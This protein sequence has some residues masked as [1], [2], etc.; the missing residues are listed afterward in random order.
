MNI[1]ALLAIVVIIAMVFLVVAVPT[2]S[3]KDEPR[4]LYLA[5]VPDDSDEVQVESLPG[6]PLVTLTL[7]GQDWVLTKAPKNDGLVQGA[8]DNGIIVSEVGGLQPGGGEL[9]LIEYYPW[10]A[11]NV[12]LPDLSAYGEVIWHRDSYILIQAS[13]ES[14]EQL[15]LMGLRLFPLDEPISA[16]SRPVKI[17]PPPT[18]PDPVIAKKVRQLRAKDIQAWDRRLS[19][20]VEV[21]IGD[22][23]M[24]LRSRYAHSANG[25][26]A[27]QYV[28][29]QLQAMGYEPAYFSYKTP[30]RKVWRDIVVDIPGEVDP[31][32]LV[33]L[34]GH[35]D[36]IS[37]PIKQAPQAAP[38]ADDNGTG[39]SSLLAMAKLLKDMRFKYT[40]RLVWFTGEEMGYWG[41]RPYVK[42][43]AKE[44]ADV[45]AA[46]NLDMIGYDGDRD[47]VMELHTGTRKANVLL[48]DHLEAANQLYDIGAVIERKE[49]SAARFSDHR[50]FWEHGY[51]SVLLIE[52]FFKNSKEEDTH[53]RDRNPAYH[54]QSDQVNLVDYKYVARTAKMAMAAAMYLAEP[55]NGAP[56]P[57][58][59][60]TTPAEAT[61][62]PIPPTP[63]VTPTPTDPP[64]ET[65]E[66]RVINGG[67][68]EN[69][70]WRGFHS[71][72][73]P[74]EANSGER[75]A[76]L[77][78]LPPSI[79]SSAD[80]DLD[81]N[82]YRRV[83]TR[84]S[85]HSSLYQTLTLPKN[86]SSIT[87][88]F[89]YWPGTDDTGRDSQR[90]YLLKPYRYTRI[91]K[92]MF[93]LENDRQ[94]KQASFDLS[95][96]AGRKVVLYFSVYNN[97]TAAKGRTWMYVDDVSIRICRP[98]T[99]AP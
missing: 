51:P 33:L 89:S 92:L 26:L 49:K 32:R 47:G 29:E 96:Y 72:Y 5:Q 56:R 81:V 97:S 80:D 88:T 57:T 19:G 48:G 82:T 98:A 68:E 1:K 41:S 23:T 45:V 86:A 10:D 2:M 85:R 76:R 79:K 15:S 38:G 25:R 75:A 64:S 91:K 39:S 71:V 12:S 99:P 59:T 24:K 3:Q 7:D 17:G 78:L 34:V 40:I 63:E 53:P 60:P 18:E 70:G 37:Y 55:V 27:E 77:G 46:I 58:A 73:T 50:S 62:T 95:R 44:N 14:A 13:E 93:V 31:D 67:F 9:Y 30:Y 54:S 65:C 4:V 74:A 20:E 21:K 94:W 69:G 42:A 16:M 66:E 6:V 87:L 35:L 28:F 11:A 22:E 90:V 43:L 83:R 52:N 84:H 61:P 36:S 8:A